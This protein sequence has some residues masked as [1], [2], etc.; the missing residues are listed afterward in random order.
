M[1][2]FKTGEVVIYKLNEAVIL[3]IE[4]NEVHLLVRGNGTYGGAATR[5]VG[6]INIRTPHLNKVS[7]RVGDVRYDDHSQSAKLTTVAGGNVNYQYSNGS[8]GTCSLNEWYRK[9][10]KT[11]K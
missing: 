7:P 11:S 3:S 6:P 2:K 1:P 4:G 5:P 9:F 8:R 10:S